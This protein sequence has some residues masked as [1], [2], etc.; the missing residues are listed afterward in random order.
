MTKEKLKINWS[1][2][3]KNDTDDEVMYTKTV[4]SPKEA[5]QS[6]KE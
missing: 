1:L 6:K 2:S 4:F 3:N 5:L